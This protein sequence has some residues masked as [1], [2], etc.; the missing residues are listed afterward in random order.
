MTRVEA[1][2]TVDPHVVVRAAAI[3][4]PIAVT[5]AVVVLRPPRPRTW[6]GVLLACAWCVP[7]LLIA[8]VVAVRAGW[9][10]FE[11]EG[12]VLLGMPVDLL[13]SWTWLW[14]A[15]P[16]LAAPGLPWPVL[17]VAALAVDLVAMPATAPVVQLGPGWLWGEAVCLSVA[18]VPALHLA[19]WTIAQVHVH[20]RAALQAV[21]FAG[22]MVF[23]VPAIAIE[24]S[25]AGWTAPLE[26]P[27]WQAMLWLQALAVPA[28][29]GLSAVQEFATRGGGTPV[30][31][32]PPMRLVTSGLYAYVRN[33][34]QL[35]ALLLLAL[36]G[37]ALENLWISAAAVMAHLYAAGLA[38]W[39]ESDDM[40]ERHGQAW[41]QYATAVPTWWPRWR[42]WWPPDMPPA[43]LYVA[44][45]CD[46]CRQVGAWLA[47]RRP[48]RLDVVA[49]ESHPSAA[50]V[51]MTYESA[52]GAY[53]ASG[54]VALARALEHVHLGWALLGAV[55][56]LPGVAFILQ[57]VVDA[58]GGG[59]RRLPTA[60]ATPAAP[61]RR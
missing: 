14:G 60:C 8:N 37:C 59:P 10:R 50:L 4:V 13:L 25:G 43:R 38:S 1:L 44:D 9:W 5:L 61:T 22:L 34:M 33:P 46:M 57:L 58:S 2:A 30:P 3:Y 6:I 7:S 40:T 51:R 42:P 53:S 26:R 54:L 28:A 35:S 39:D 56:R 18:F 29:M 55:V 19:R 31:F 36:L 24:G 23:V 12:G 47:V 21:A 16:Q 49:A 45:S 48:R 17:V 52:D 11:A 20:A 27:R 41:T 32:D 15:I